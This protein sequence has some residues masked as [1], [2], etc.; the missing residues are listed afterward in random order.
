MLKKHIIYSLLISFFSLVATDESYDFYGR[1]FIASYKECNKEALLDKDML[2]KKLEEAVVASGA[3]ILSSSYEEFPG[4]GITLFIVLSESHASIHTYPEH[5]SCFVDL[6][7]CGSRC[8]HEPF[9][10]VLINYLEPQKLDK[11]L[12]TRE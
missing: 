7:T 2:K 10:A 8:Q 4:G 6:F 1:H 9:D 5:A 11:E 3:T 12:I